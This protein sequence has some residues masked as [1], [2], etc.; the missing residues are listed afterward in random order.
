MTVLKGPFIIMNLT[1]NVV[2][3]FT[4]LF[5]V[6]SNKLVLTVTL[7]QVAFI[8]VGSFTYFFCFVVFNIQ[9]LFLQF[10]FSN[11][12]LLVRDLVRETAKK[13][14]LVPL[15]VFTFGFLLFVLSESIL[16]VSIFWASFHFNSSPFVSFQ[17]VLFI[18]DP[19]ELTY[20]NTLLLSNAAVSL[21][22]TIRSLFGFTHFASL[23]GALAWTFLS[24]QI[25][26]FR[27]LG[28]YVSDSVY[29]C[30]FFSLSGLHFFHVVVGL[31]IIGMQI[32]F[33]EACVGYYVYT[34]QDLYFTIQVLYWHFV[35][36]VWLFILYQIP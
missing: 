4:L 19:C 18:P 32:S 34:S 14:C 22:C 12:F 1:V 17:E 26:E 33:P 21:G 20:G 35:E 28:F 31:V 23:S 13:C 29:G 8:I 10:V 3:Y 5:N 6:M 25:K 27:N 9:L 7:I 11:Y 24:L 36:V 2:L 15:G 16:F 30:V